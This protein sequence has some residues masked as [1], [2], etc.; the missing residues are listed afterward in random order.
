MPR[1]YRYYWTKEDLIQQ[2]KRH[3]EDHYTEG[4][5]D[6]IVECWDDEQIANQ[7]GRCTTVEG[8]IKKFKDVVSVYAD[9]QADAIN[10]V[11]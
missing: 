10:S 9:R 7:I 1:K 11:F 6:V 2:I 4:G 5:W 3:A 8:A